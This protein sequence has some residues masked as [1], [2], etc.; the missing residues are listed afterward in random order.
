MRP[1]VRSLP[2]PSPLGRGAPWRRAALALLVV[3]FCGAAADGSDAAANAGAAPT[4]L[5][6]DRAGRCRA[7]ADALSA[8]RLPSEPWVPELLT[9]G[10]LS[11]RY[12][13]DFSCAGY[14]WGEAE[15]DAGRACVVVDVQLFGAVP[16]DGLDETVAL[17]AAL[18]YAH[19]VEG[20]VVV[21]LPRGRLILRDQIEIH[22]YELVLRGAGS[23]SSLYE[24]QRCLRLGEP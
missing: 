14:R 15:P 7:R 12:L 10:P 24:Y 11:G 22:R 19:V 13:P 21:Q 2:L 5:R 23:S 18:A 4:L 17:K 1:A 8:P 20:P 9:S 16:D 3:A 6:L